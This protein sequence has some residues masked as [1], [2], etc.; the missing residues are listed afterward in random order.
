MCRKSI[1]I[2]KERGTRQQFSL[3][4]IPGCR[5]LHHCWKLLQFKKSPTEGANMRS[6]LKKKHVRW[7]YKVL[8]YFRY[9]NASSSIQILTEFYF[10]QT[11]ITIHFHR[12]CA[13]PATSILTCFQ[14]TYVIYFIIIIIINW[15]KSSILISFRSI[16][17]KSIL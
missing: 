17:F 11:P 9:K 13:V 5:I 15:I 16:I 6:F 1:K 10:S 3:N 4:L 8:Y 7:F 14:N 12:K 2:K